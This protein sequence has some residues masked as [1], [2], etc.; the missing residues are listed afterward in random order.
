[1]S[2]NILKHSIINKESAIQFGDDYTNGKIEDAS[3]IKEAVEEAEK[4]IKS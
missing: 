4:N 3:L 1:M 2:Q